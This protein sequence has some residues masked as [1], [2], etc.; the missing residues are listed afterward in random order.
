MAMVMLIGMTWKQ[1]RILRIVGHHISH[2]CTIMHSEVNIIYVCM[3]YETHLDLWRNN[4][5]HFIVSTFLHGRHQICDL[6]RRRK[7]VKCGGRGR[8]I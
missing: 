8:E 3:N 4:D 7:V 1:R 2:F 6:R 5:E